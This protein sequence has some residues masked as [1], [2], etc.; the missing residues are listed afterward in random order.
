MQ[1]SGIQLFLWGRWFLID[2]TNNHTQTI[3]RLT[4]EE[5]F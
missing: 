2:K 4:V 1:K 3:L 5:N